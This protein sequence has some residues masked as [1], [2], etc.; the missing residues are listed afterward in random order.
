MT[1]NWLNQHEHD[2]INT[3]GVSVKFSGDLIEHIIQIHF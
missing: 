1:S 2:E 3:F